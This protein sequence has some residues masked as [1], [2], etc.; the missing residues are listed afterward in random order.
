MWV[1]LGLS[2]LAGLVGGG[3]SPGKPLYFG[4]EKQKGVT[5][6]AMREPGREQICCGVKQ[7]LTLGLVKLEIPV[8]SPIA[9]TC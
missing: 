3:R 1:W 8:S 6:T 7:K 5:L 4:L 9:V 2:G